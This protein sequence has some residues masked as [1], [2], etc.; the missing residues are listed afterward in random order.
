[1]LRLPFCLFAFCVSLAGVRTRRNGVWGYRLPTFVLLVTLFS[2]RTAGNLVEL[3]SAFLPT[4]SLP[5][6]GR[7]ALCAGRLLKHMRELERRRHGGA[8]DDDDDEMEAE[9]EW[10]APQGPPPPPL[11]LSGHAA[12]LTP[13]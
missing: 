7:F 1:M 4:S 10:E 5:V 11:V 9:E 6:T 3:S 13:Y 8:D 2:A 12:S